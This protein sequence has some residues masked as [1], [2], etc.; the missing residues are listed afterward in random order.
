MKQNIIKQRETTLSEDA[1]HSSSECEHE[2]E[3][4][5]DLDQH[6]NNNESNRALISISLPQPTPEQLNLMK[7]ETNIKIGEFPENV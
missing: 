7:S 1:A 2:Y 4:P 5:D 3:D 6:A